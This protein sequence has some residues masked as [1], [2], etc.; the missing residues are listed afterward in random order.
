MSNQLNKML[1]IC[2]FGENCLSS[3]E[4]CVR[5][6]KKLTNRIFLIDMKSDDQI[7]LETEDLGIQ[8]IDASSLLSA[9]QS[10]WVLFVKPEERPVLSSN[11]NLCSSLGNRLIDGYAVSVKSIIEP[12]LLEP[13]Q[14]VK[15]LGQLKNVSGAT[16]IS[17]L[18]L[19]LLRRIHAVKGLNI[20]LDGPSR[21]WPGLE[22]NIGRIDNI[23]V[24]SYGE[25]EGEVQDK[26]KEHDIRCLK[27]ELKFGPSEEDNMVELTEGIIGFSVLHM[28]YLK[29]FMESARLGLGNDKIYLT[30]LHYLG[31]EGKFR[32]AKD[33][34]EAWIIKRHDVEKWDIYMRAGFIYANLLD[35]DNAINCYGKVADLNKTYGALSNL[36]KLYL[37]K[38]KK[39][40]ALSYLE[41]ATELEPD[42]FDRQIVSIISKEGWKMRRLSV[43]MIARDEEK[44][45]QQ[46]LES[47]VGIADEV[48]VVDTGSSDK[49]KEIVREFGGKV[50]EA[51]WQ[52]DFSAARNVGL[53]EATGDYIL[54][55]DADEFVDSRQRFG[56]LLAKCLLP[57]AREARA[58]MVKV[59]PEKEAA[60]LSVSI[61]SKFTGHEQEEYQIRLFPGGMGIQFHGAAFETIDE[62]LH[63]LGIEVA[64]NDIFKI[65]H[66]KPDGK[67]RDQRKVPAV[68]KYFE[69]IR[70]PAKAL[71]GGLFFLRLGDLDRAYP[72]LE[73]TEKMEPALS[74]KIARLYSMKNQH[75]RAKKIIKKGLEYSPES[76]DLILALAEVHHKQGQYNKVRNLLADRIDVIK[77]D[78]DPEAA[79]EASYY[80]G[81]ALLEADLLAE[82]VE[83][84]AYSSENNPLDTRYKIGS[85]YAFSKADQWEQVLEVAGQ[86]VNE[87]KINIDHEI[88]DF[89]DVG[90]VFIEL[91]RHFAGSNNS[92]EANIC[93]K[94]LEHIIRTR[95]SNK[96][97]VEKM[98]QMLGGLSV[99]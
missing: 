62:S 46:S 15:N 52:D 28:G 17:R 65:T 91:V 94:I 92:E 76:S 23:K 84:I 49:T 20:I 85:L 12:S 61:L 63:H 19:R 96:E 37:V 5:H 3:L 38:G 25:E 98:T 95:I 75:D 34:F 18:E 41:M 33:L 80:Y 45:I 97:E 90:L 40:R 36:G 57:P 44:A 74:A 58:Y 83:H 8:V 73:K 7:K 93:H 14:W 50:I 22:G 47:I 29:S 68:M 13:Y 89:S 43:C 77:K 27:G 66:S 71:E 72:W 9:L 82:G 99:S 69:I 60:E 39:E 1:S 55:M 54:C 79:A 30:M 81:I 56:L 78:L 11:E 4:Q 88:K 48:I 59:E 42:P 10:E 26:G 86:V 51:E 35:V 16:Y 31:R 87:E 2:I 70:D 21:E 24:E 32:E 64:G 6:A 67:A 53:Q